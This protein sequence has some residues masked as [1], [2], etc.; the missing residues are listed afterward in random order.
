VW[1]AHI[2]AGPT[3]SV[4]ATDDDVDRYVDAYGRFVDELC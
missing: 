4:A 3:C 2:G 1:E